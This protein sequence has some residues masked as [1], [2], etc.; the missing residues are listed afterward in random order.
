MSNISSSSIS[1]LREVLL[2]QKANL[3]ENKKYLQKPSE[4]EVTEAFLDSKAVN[5]FG[6]E[7]LNFNEEK[8]YLYLNS[9]DRD[10]NA[11]PTP[12]EYMIDLPSEVTNIIKVDLVQASLPTT[13]RNVTSTNNIIRFS[14]SPHSILNTVRIPPGCYTG[15]TLALEIMI[16]MNVALYDGIVSVGPLDP[17]TGYITSCTGDQVKVTWIEQKRR[18]VFQYVDQNRVASASSLTLYWSFENDMSVILGFDADVVQT[19]GVSTA[20]YYAINTNTDYGDILGPSVSTDVRYTLSLYGNK[21]CD[22]KGDNVVILSINPFN[23]NDLVS[24][25]G[26]AAQSSCFGVLNIKWDY[27]ATI[28]ELNNNNYP[29]QKYYRE[30]VSRAKQILVKFT[31]LRD[32]LIDFDGENNFLTLRI[33][34]KRTQPDK[35]LF[36]R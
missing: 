30:G 5:W 18:I 36:A 13:A 21:A 27:N 3:E 28:F 2:K 4:A 34:T 12:A 14:V 32:E 25:R 33:T 8:V 35:S 20:G 24:S 23:D 19:Y 17:D 29:I 9:A 15:T 10:T 31:N 16:Q 6:D 7:K 11:W 26:I 1:I 22:L